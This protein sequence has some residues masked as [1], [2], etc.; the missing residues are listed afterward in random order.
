MASG[1]N[2]GE[3]RRKENDERAVSANFRKREMKTV[4]IW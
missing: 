2:E 3:E 1:P 4:A